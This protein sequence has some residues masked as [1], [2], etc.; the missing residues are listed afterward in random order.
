MHF[1]FEWSDYLKLNYLTDRIL[2]VLI[3]IRCKFIYIRLFLCGLRG[4]ARS[5]R[6]WEV[7]GELYV[8]FELRGRIQGLCCC[9]CFLCPR[10]LTST[11]TYPNLSTDLY[12]SSFNKF[13]VTAQKE[14]NIKSW[15][16]WFHQILFCKYLSFRN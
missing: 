10:S 12:Y 3:G 1:Q 13:S 5:W 14:Q 16:W 15:Y 4:F 6:R 2:W 9:N 8:C 7:L 11:T